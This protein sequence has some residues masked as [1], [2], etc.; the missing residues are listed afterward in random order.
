MVNKFI[1]KSNKYICALIAV[2]AGA[3]SSATLDNPAAWPP[4]AAEREFL[5]ADLNLLR[6]SLLNDKE[7][8]TIEI[9]E[10]IQRGQKICEK[11]AFLSTPFIVDLFLHFPKALDKDNIDLLYHYQLNS[12][13]HQNYMLFLRSDLQKAMIDFVS[14][15][16]PLDFFYD[17]ISDNWYNKIPEDKIEFMVEK[18]F[19]VFVQ[20]HISSC[21]QDINDPLYC[22]TEQKKENIRN[23]YISRMTK[24]AKVLLSNSKYEKTIIKSVQS[25][26]IHENTT[27]AK[28]E[29]KYLFFDTAVEM[30]SNSLADLP[31]QGRFLWD[32]A[33][34]RAKTEIAEA[35]REV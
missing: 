27:K 1:K 5:Y 25:L 30:I 2:F 8:T 18:I 32:E 21:I 35:E 16:N 7:H 20:R 10:A 29:K 33:I 31:E 34:S 22:D 12:Y 11:N 17:M 15:A 3:F 19:P 28:S 26:K 14:I 23:N 4:S 13:H 24:L 9:E 6:T